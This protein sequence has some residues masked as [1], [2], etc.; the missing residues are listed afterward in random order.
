MTL[1]T[2]K[3][4]TIVNTE[5]SNAMNTEGSEIAKD[6][7]RILDRYLSKKMGNEVEGESEIVTSDVSEVVDGIMPTLMRIFTIADNLAS[8]DPTGPE[9]IQQAE[10]E[11]DYVSH[12]FWKDN[13]DSFMDLYC[14]MFDAVSGQIGVAQGW[15]NSEE[16]VTQES[17]E[18]LELEEVADLL[19][20]EELEPV[21]RSENEDGT[22]NIVF[23]RRSKRG[24]CDWESIPPDEYRISADANK[25]DP[26]GA[27]MVGRECLRT[28]SQLIEMGFQ[29]SQINELRAAK[30]SRQK[31]K[32]DERNNDP[33]DRSQDYILLREAYLKVDF[34]EDGVAELRQVFTGNGDLLKWEET[35]EIANEVVDRQPYHV[36]CAGP[37]SHKHFGRSPAEKTVDI[38]DT[39]TTLLR[40]VLMNLYHTNNPGHAVAEYG[41]TENT[42]DD[43]MTTRVGRIARFGRNPNEV[44]APIQVPFTAAATFPMLEYFDSVK[45][46]RTG[47]HADSQ[48]LAP[49]ELKNIQTTVMSQSMDLSR[50]KI[51][52][53]ARLFAETGI[54]S[55]FQHIHELL[56][57]HQDKERIVMLRNTYVP[58]KPSA[59][60]TRYNMTL[61]VGLGI[62]TR[63]QNLL[64]LASIKD[65]QFEEMQNGG[66]NLT[67]TPKNRYNLFVEV[68]KNA[69]LKDAA[70]FF[71]DPGD[72]MDPPPEN[73][74]QKLEKLQAENEARQQ[75]IDQ[76]RL[77]F[78]IEKLKL[79]YEKLQLLH[80]REM[81]GLET[82]NQK[83]LD[84]FM[85]AN[86]KLRN[87]IAKL[88]RE[89]RKDEAMLS[90]DIAEKAAKVL[91]INADTKL[92]SAQA[93]KSV[94]EAEAID[95]ET[96]AND[97]GITELLEATGESEAE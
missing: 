20:D 59:W 62:G 7:R 26:C 21:E 41:M 22:H 54:K 87:D 85:I 60:K 45:R 19:D 29:K 80:E 16:V 79:D 86:E 94:S 46:D 2:D 57:K 63:E 53:I 6:R 40:Q 75:Q 31:D 9:D 95:Q 35:G 77:Q 73:E 18:N 67:I 23:Q 78:N 25:L 84:D 42:L 81:L 50:Q 33:A 96:E 36:L 11:S 10:Q 32:A 76:E 28:R 70:M 1:S 65:L 52:L 55:L 8:F 43:L 93:L 89:A 72:Q 91:N 90:V 71:T 49:S 24:K 56:M 74:A 47:V 12:V 82:Q 51:E 66:R 37:L 4:K 97:A 39:T 34:D 44:Y 38:Q 58:V 13:P 92:K 17:Y 64:H 83:R 88:Q 30:D 14:W 48:G 61:Q 27:R 68:V 69:N 15:W 5:F 3:L